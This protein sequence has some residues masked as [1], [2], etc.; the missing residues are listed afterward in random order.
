MIADIIFTALF[1]AVILFYWFIE[2]G[3]WIKLI[4]EDKDVNNR[5]LLII[6]GTIGNLLVFYIFMHI[7][8]INF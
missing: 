6:I 2:I 8:N 3:G 4:M 7:I 1:I 5:K